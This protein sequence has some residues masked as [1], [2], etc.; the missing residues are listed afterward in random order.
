[1][2]SPW[3][4]FGCAVGFGLAAMWILVGLPAAL[5]CLLSATG[6][7]VV[8][9]AIERAR[10]KIKVRASS[11]GDSVPGM[12]ALLGRTPEV[13]DLARQAD[14]LNHDIGYVYEPTVATLPPAGEYGSP[15]NGDT[16]A[17]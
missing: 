6:G 10:G 5:V 3:R 9:V 16:A 8:V 1:M 11:P 4:Y 2:D 12:L 13:S 15:L 7:Y 14:E 17:N